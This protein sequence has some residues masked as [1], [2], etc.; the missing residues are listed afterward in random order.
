[1]LYQPLMFLQMAPVIL[2]SFETSQLVSKYDIHKVRVESV[3]FT[4]DSKCLISLGGLDDSNIIVWNIEKEEV[5]CGVTAS[6]GTSG[7]AALLCCTNLR[8]QCFVTGGEGTLRVWKVIADTKQAEA[9]DVKFGL[10][11]RHIISMVIDELDVFAFCG[12]TTGDIVKIKLNYDADI[13][14]LDPAATPILLGCFGKYIGK[15]RLVTGEEPARYSQG[16]TALCLLPSDM[17]GRI[18]VGAGDG[19]VELVKELKTVTFPEPSAIRKVKMLSLPQLLVLKSTNVNA[20]PTSLLLVQTTVFIGTMLS[21]IFT[22]DLETFEV[23]LHVTCHRHSIYD[24]AF[25]HEYSEV[26]ATCSKDDIRVWNTETSLELLRIT[27]PN[28][29]CTCIQFACDGKSIV[30][31][32]NDGKIRAFTPQTGRLIYEIHNAHSK[33]VTAVAITTCGLQVVSGGGEGQVRVWKI[34]PTY[35]KLQGILQEHKSS[36]SCIQI[37]SSDTEAVSVSLDGSCVIWDIVKLARK[38]SLFAN[39]QFM[40][41]CYHPSGVQI[42][43][44]GSD[45]KIG[46]WEL[47]DASLIREIEGSRSSGLN[48][49]DIT[50]DGERIVTGG[51]DQ[52][53]KVWNYHKGNP[54]HVGADHA[55]AVTAARFSPDNRYIVSVT[56]DGGIFLWKSPYITLPLQESWQ[57]ARCSSRSTR[58]TCSE[59][60]E[61]QG[62]LA[63]EREVEEHAASARSA[64]GSKDGG[65]HE[66]RLEQCICN[67]TAKS[68]GTPDIGG[69]LKRNGMPKRGGT[70]KSNGTPKSGGTTKSNGTPNNSQGTSS[71][72]L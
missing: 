72:K 25:P 29:T 21:E 17:E 44:T 13:D 4:C 15:K 60:A 39:T 26:F 40:G 48:A 5:L 69:M 42:V 27:V 37:S 47:Y 23:K 49:V 51:N 52:C 3:A 61:Q 14:V 6:R 43:T 7:N 2:W 30:S 46:Y 63:A 33:G 12:T 71:G 41:V 9:V 67:G 50:R 68:V 53:V 1:M 55:G 24:I 31:G 34:T 65:I 38:R 59:Q 19:T 11:K 28:F 45:R 70:T 32:W 57:S 8:G 22:V 36:V 20:A 35:Q 56:S 64:Q 16:V 54:T 18:V 10:I 58:S 62:K 66:T